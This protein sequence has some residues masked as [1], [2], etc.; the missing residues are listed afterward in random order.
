LIHTLLPLLKKYK[1]NLYLSGHDHSI[2]HKEDEGLHCLV[3]G[4]GSRSTPVTDKKDFTP[5]SSTTGVAYVRT[6]MTMLEFGFY[7]L[8]GEVIFQKIINTS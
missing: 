7:N 8:N 5:L 4:T 1:V 2:C 3:S 6:S